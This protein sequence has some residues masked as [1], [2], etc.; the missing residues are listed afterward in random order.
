MNYETFVSVIS[1][2]VMPLF[3]Q[4]KSCLN[5]WTKEHKIMEGEYITY[6]SD[7]FIQELKN[8]A[9]ILWYLWLVNKENNGFQTKQQSK[10]TIHDCWKA[11]M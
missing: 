2:F 1:K 5:D 3:K 7:K 8:I 6:W 11:E 4:V 9:F 10:T